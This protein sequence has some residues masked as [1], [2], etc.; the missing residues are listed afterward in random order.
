MVTIILIIKY[1]GVHIKLNYLNFFDV[2][3]LISFC[4]NA[5]VFP[6]LHLLPHPPQELSHMLQLPGLGKEGFPKA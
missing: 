1:I 3:G 5:N 4:Q 2:F 6:L